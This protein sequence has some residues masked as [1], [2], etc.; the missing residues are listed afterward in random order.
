LGENK[1]NFSTLTDYEISMLIIERNTC[2]YKI[3]QIEELLK[4]IEKAKGFS[5]DEK[6]SPV[7]SNKSESKQLPGP[8]FDKLPWMSYKTKQAA[9][10]NEAAWIFYNTEGAEALRAIMNANVGDAKIGNFEYQRQGP[11]GKFIARKPI[12]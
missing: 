10:P 7:T 8:D 1:L 11:E 2:H 9:G 12:K 6:T 5:D 3:E 4:R